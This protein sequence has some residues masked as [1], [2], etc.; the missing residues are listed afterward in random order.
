MVLL[1]IIQELWLQYLQLSG[2]SECMV[3]DFLL[4]GRVAAIIEKEK[5]SY[6]E[7]NEKHIKSTLRLEQCD[8]RL[9]DAMQQN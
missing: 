7:N 2:D 4:N 8:Q 1:G 5:R 9:F 3:F 6:F